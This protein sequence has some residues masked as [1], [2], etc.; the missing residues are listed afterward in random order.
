MGVHDKTGE[1]VQILQ[2]QRPS[3]QV[4]NILSAG[5]ICVCGHYQTS[6]GV[7][8]QCSSF[9]IEFQPLGNMVMGNI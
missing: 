3:T 5:S 6:S 7:I 8:F 2:R 4:Y 1:R 9:I